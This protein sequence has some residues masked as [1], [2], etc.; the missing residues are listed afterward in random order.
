MN[1][2]AFAPARL[3]TLHLLRHSYFPIRLELK[4][5]F[6]SDG[7]Q[8]FIPVITVTWEAEIKRIAAQ[9]QSDKKVC[10]TPSQ[11]KKTEHHDLCLSSQLQQEM[12]N[13]HNKKDCRHGSSSKVPAY[14]AQSLE[15]KPQYCQ[16]NFSMYHPNHIKPVYC[17]D[18]IC[19]TYRGL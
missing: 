16:K 8:W 10:K 14:Q 19:L 5:L 7:L 2:L 11:G 15:F 18:H 9:G 6:L 13:N 12:Q 17:I 4:K 3:L 1:T